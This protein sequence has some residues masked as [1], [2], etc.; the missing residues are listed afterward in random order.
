MTSGS[1]RCGLGRIELDRQ[2]KGCVL[3]VSPALEPAGHVMEVQSVHTRSCVAEHGCDSYWL[4]L[5]AAAHDVAS[6]VSVPRETAGQ[7]REPPQSVVT[8]CVSVEPL[9]ARRRWPAGHRM[10]A[11]AV[12][13]RF[14]VDEH[15]C[16]SY[17]LPLHVA[18]AA[19]TRSCV[20]VHACVWYVEPAVHVSHSI[21]LPSTHVCVHSCDVSIL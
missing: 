1:R 17:W 6:V 20:G 5:H 12:H 14:C 15:G 16:D 7:K 18:Q 9:Q 19:Q 3:P 2:G 21:H 4:P 10:E 8:H 13:T 11:Q